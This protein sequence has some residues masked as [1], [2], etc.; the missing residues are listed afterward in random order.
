MLRPLVDTSVE[1]YSHVCAELLPTPAKSHYTFS[2]RDV[3]KA[4]QGM[5]AI[6]PNQC[7]PGDPRGTLMR[8][9]VHEHMRVYHD[10]WVGVICEFWCQFRRGM[11]AGRRL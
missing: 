4:F 9:W 1:V 6:R 2:L 8:L 10:R 11:R 7:G 5:L 3:S